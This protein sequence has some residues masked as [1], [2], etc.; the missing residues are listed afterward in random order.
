MSAIA[1]KPIDAEAENAPTSGGLFFLDL[2]AGRILSRKP[3]WL[4]FEEHHQRR[5]EVARWSGARCRRW[6]HLLDQYG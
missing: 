6:A 2:S 5:P 4:R 3:G 1:S